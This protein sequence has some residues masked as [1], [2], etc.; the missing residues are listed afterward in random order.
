ME[1]AMSEM[2]SL[3]HQIADAITATMKIWPK[4]TELKTCEALEGREGERSFVS[5]NPRHVV[6]RQE[7]VWKGSRAREPI[8]LAYAFAELALPAC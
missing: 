5:K 8:V 4:L 1:P 6:K 3:C 7:P 2:F